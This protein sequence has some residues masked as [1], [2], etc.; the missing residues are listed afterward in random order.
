MRGIGRELVE[1]GIHRQPQ[2]ETRRLRDVDLRPGVVVEGAV[3]EHES[4]GN[5]RR[6]ADRARHRH[7]ERR[8]LVAVA[9]LRAQHVA[10]DGKLTVGFLSRAR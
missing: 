5:P 6:D 1:R 2:A 7:E 8:V 10:A 3:H 4:D 9:D